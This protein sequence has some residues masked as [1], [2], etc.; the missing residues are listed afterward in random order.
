ML[1]RLL[2]IIILF[3]LSFTILNSVFANEG[4]MTLL[5]ITN[6]N[7]TLEG[8]TADLHLRI[9][10][11]SGHV[12]M[13]TFPLTKLD[14][15]I[16]I[17]FAKE[18][19]CDYLDDIDCSRSDFFYTIRSDSVIIGGPSAG[20]ALTV[21]TVST[22]KGWDIDEK[23]TITG[24]INPGGFIGRVGGVAEKIEAAGK[25]DIQ[26]VLV[27]KGAMNTNLSY[28]DSVLPAG[29]NE[30]K[31]KSASIEEVA[32]NTGIE[33]VQ[34]TSLDQVIYEFSG[35]KPKRKNITLDAEESYSSFMRNISVGLCKRTE[36]LFNETEKTNSS[37]YD[38]ALNLSKR[39]NPSFEA[40]A[41]Y[42]SASFCFGANINLAYLYYLQKNMSEIK[43]RAQ[44]ED[45][46]RE[47]DALADKVSLS[48]KKTINDLQ[49]FM[50][51]KERL[52]EA[53]QY[54][55]KAADS[56]EKNNTKNAIYNL[57]Y[58][59]ERAKS[60]EFW[61]RFLKRPGKVFDINPETLKR[62]C[63]QKLSEAEERYQYANLHLP[64]GLKDTRNELDMAYQDKANE[65]YA[66]CLFKAS[67]A[68]AEADLLLGS[69]GLTE[70]TAQD[71]IN[72]K[73]QAIEEI[74]KRQQGK[75]IFP[76]LGYSYYEYAKSLKDTDQY[77]S[78]LYAEYA[79]EL[80]KLDIYFQGV[81]KKTI[82]ARYIDYEVMFYFLV[83]SLF[84]VLLTIAFYPLLKS[85]KGK[86]GDCI[87]INLRKHR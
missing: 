64:G 60:A 55:E 42:S 71:Y 27:P 22:L 75:N 72:I 65:D 30:T 76:I 51:V 43:I 52:T 41:Y 87:S 54:L 86:K 74:I 7:G 67:K 32:Q 15:Q 1:K 37:L 4:E 12:Y 81:D 35:Q 34:V 82:S 78:L 53:N 61:A 9:A 2:G 70:N 56:L 40:G 57:A 18:I 24:T 29:S 59:R 10:P 21:L 14:T 6:E 66:L 84:G 19:A 16:S 79:I 68:K 80:S 38:S 26:K 31:Q 47:I 3:V 20:S 33:L 5:A 28:N 46:S 45:I 83:G 50:V 13:D 8:S 63:I 48:S 44:M 69:L 49:T 39:A 11:G 58:G 36:K 77:S 25:A 23:T 17:R 73:L 62:S 85:K